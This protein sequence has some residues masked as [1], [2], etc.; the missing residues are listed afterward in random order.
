MRV[1]ISIADE[2]L[3]SAKLRARE[4][5]QTLSGFVEYALG[6]ELS[7]TDRAADRPA[8]PVFRGGNGLMPGV[9]INSN[10]ALQEFLDEG[11]PFEKLR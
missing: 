1:I 9:D 11:L 5:G 6:R 10:R 7:R 8:V 3:E 2:L 4:R